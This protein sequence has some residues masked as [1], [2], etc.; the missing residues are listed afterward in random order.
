MKED[1]PAY[2]IVTS[3]PR[4]GCDQEMVAKHKHDSSVHVSCSADS[5]APWGRL[6]PVYS[7]ERD[8]IYV[9]ARCARC[10]GVVDAESWYPVLACEKENAGRIVNKL[11]GVHALEQFTMLPSCVVFFYYR[12]ASDLTNKRCYIDPISTCPPDA[13]FEP[14]SLS[15]SRN[16]TIKEIAHACDSGLNSPTFVGDYIYKNVFCA[17]CN[18][19]QFS[20]TMA[21]ADEVSSPFR[22]VFGNQITFLLDSRF[23]L[24]STGVSQTAN[25]PK[26]CIQDGDRPVRKMFFFLFCL[27]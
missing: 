14:I 19:K 24:K 8:E 1:T 11:K 4:D 16:M 15:D 9:N 7:K 26:V 17:L 6:F 22:S 18:E 10:H 20:D 12:D 2:K 21:C 3:A 23:Y 13:S 5:V 27:F 25:I